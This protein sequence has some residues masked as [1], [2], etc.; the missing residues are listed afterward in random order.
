MF[1]H[2]KAVHRDPKDHW[3]GSVDVG[4]LNAHGDR[5]LFYSILWRDG[6]PQG[7]RFVGPQ[8]AARLFAGL[9]LN[10]DGMKR[11]IKRLDLVYAPLDCT[12]ELDQ[13]EI[14]TLV[15]RDVANAPAAE[16]RTFFER[17]FEPFLFP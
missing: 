10:T 13:D 7:L 8:P 5:I 9:P 11:M 12:D 6:L 17:A 2:C 16:K 15:L 14:R 4:I 3:F 1:S